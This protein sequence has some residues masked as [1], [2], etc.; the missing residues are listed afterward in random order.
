MAF[1]VIGAFQ[2]AA[3]EVTARTSSIS[4]RPDIAQSFWVTIEIGLVTAMQRAA[5]SA[6]CWPTPSSWAGCRASFG[7]LDHVRERRLELRGRAARAGV[8][9]HARPGRPRHGVP[10][11]HA[12]FDPATGTTPRCNKIGLEIVYTLLRIR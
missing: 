6:S 11:G 12:G 5:S 8:H 1:L 3:G 7:A 10:E 2:G 4:R 9:L